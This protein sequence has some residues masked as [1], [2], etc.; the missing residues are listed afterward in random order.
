MS[1]QQPMGPQ[2]LRHY[3]MEAEEEFP[4][5]NPALALEKY[6]R[7]YKIKGIFFWEDGKRYLWG[8]GQY[9]L[10]R[11]VLLVDIKDLGQCGKF[12]VRPR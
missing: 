8:P 9:F 6:A 5:D 7:Q 4:N 11:P 1:L 3:R 10:I 12:I 2:V